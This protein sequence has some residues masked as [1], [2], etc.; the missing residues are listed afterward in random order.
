MKASEKGCMHP[1]K[2]CE[3]C[4][5]ELFQAYQFYL[6]VQESDTK[7][8]HFILVEETDEEEDEITN[9]ES[10]KIET[11]VL[12]TPIEESA[13]ENDKIS[14][15][16]DCE[17]DG[18]SVSPIDSTSKLNNKTP[19]IQLTNK[20]T[21]LLLNA[22]VKTK[23][24]EFSKLKRKQAVSTQQ[25]ESNLKR[26]KCDT[27]KSNE[28]IMV[29]QLTFTSDKVEEADGNNSDNLDDCD[30]YNGQTTKTLNIGAVQLTDAFNFDS[31]SIDHLKDEVNGDDE[32]YSCKYCPKAFSSKF[33]LVVHTRKSH[34]CQFCLKSFAKPAELHFHV[35]ETHNKFDC[36]ICTKSFINNGNL[37]SHLRNT[38]NIKLPANVSLIKMQKIDV[39]EK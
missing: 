13:D 36:N 1:K 3:E 27:P 6:K 30:D 12:H 8:T 23:I 38:H 4:A 5:S 34:L 2:I 39:Q 20:V 19:N 21:S 10:R 18:S 35:K 15:E 32:I 29:P 7:L 33:H 25:R 16:I 28:L 17:S 14:T 11:E 31:H 24:G 26:L 22:G 9:K 37:R